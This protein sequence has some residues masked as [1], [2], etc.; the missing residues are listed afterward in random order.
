M[1]FREIFD[2]PGLYVADSFSPGVA[3]K[4]TDDLEARLVVYE[5]DQDFSPVEDNLL[6]YKGLFDKDYT[7]VYTRQKLF[8]K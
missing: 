6:V 7:P 1:T 3:I 8:K 4:I 5:N 2:N